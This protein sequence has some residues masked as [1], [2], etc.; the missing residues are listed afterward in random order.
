MGWIIA[1][2]VLIVLL[3]LLLC[4]VTVIFDFRGDI[5]LRISYLFFTIVKIPAKKKKTR[6]KDKKAK[7]AAKSAIKATEAAETSEV[8]GTASESEE[9]PE[10]KSGSN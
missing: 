10:K 7:K 8:G 1:G 6:K 5:Y 4:N 3:I 9:V 2:A